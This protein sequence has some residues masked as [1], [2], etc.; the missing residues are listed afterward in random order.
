MTDLSRYGYRE[1]DLAME[2]LKSYRNE[3]FYDGILGE[4][5]K[6]MFNC[7]SGNVFLT[8]EDYNVAMM[9]GEKLERFY[10]CGNCGHEGFAEEF[11]EVEGDDEYLQCPH[12]EGEEG[13]VYKAC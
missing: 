7:Y 2:L 13:K 11:D 12:C 6:V 5:M 8:D 9:N 4:G 10:S 1:L 3:P